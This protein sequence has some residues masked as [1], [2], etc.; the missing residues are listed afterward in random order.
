MD[1]RKSIWH[2]ISGETLEKMKDIRK[3]KLEDSLRS[4]KD[5]KREV[6]SK[7]GGR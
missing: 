7:N 3:T 1:G 2:S 6:A 4:V 5:L